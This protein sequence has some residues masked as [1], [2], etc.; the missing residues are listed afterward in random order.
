MKKINKFTK[1]TIIFTI[2][3]V[4]YLLLINT[5]GISLAGL[6]IDLVIYL[7]H[8]YSLHSIL[9]PIYP[10]FSKVIFAI[11]PGLTIS[12]VISGIIAVIQTFKT[13][14]R[15]RFFIVMLTLAHVGVFLIYLTSFYFR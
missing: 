4:I 9:D 6:L 3:Y 11:F 5:F 2:L 13:K 8:T 1:L 10:Y 7:S 15:D 12:A 14:E